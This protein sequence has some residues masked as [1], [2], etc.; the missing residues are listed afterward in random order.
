MTIHNV[1][2]KAVDTGPHA[3]MNIISVVR[4]PGWSAAPLMQS[5]TDNRPREIHVSEEEKKSMEHYGITS[6]TKVTY[7][8]KQHRYENIS[9]ALRFAELESV[10]AE[11]SAADKNR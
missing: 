11:E 7:S 10:R 9:D 2:M 6:T 3:I 1:V 8:Y 4:G 5:T